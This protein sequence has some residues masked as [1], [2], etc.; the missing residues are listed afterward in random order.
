MLEVNICSKTKD[1]KKRKEIEEEILYQNRMLQIL[2]FMGKYEKRIIDFT[3]AFNN[4]LTVAMQKLKGHYPNDALTC[5]EQAHKDLIGMRR[6]YE[7]QREFEKYLININKKTNE[8]YYEK[9]NINVNC[10]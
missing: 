6:I 10:S 2:D 4:L 7:K 5:L 8:V 9:I 1:K 3:Q